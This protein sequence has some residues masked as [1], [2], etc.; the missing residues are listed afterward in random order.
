MIDN[1][2]NT[3]ETKAALG[4]AFPSLEITAI[5]ELGDFLSIKT[6][7]LHHVCKRLAAIQRDNGFRKIW[8][9]FPSD[10]AVINSANLIANGLKRIR[11]EPTKTMQRAKYAIYHELEAL[12]LEHRNLSDCLLCWHLAGQNADRIEARLRVLAP[13]AMLEEAHTSAI[14][15]VSAW[16]RFL[17]TLELAASEAIDRL[18]GPSY[19]ISLKEGNHAKRQLVGVA[20]PKLFTELTG[21]TL[22]T[23]KSFE[24]DGTNFINLCLKAIGQGPLSIETI[25]THLKPLRQSKRNKQSSATA[26]CGE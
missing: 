26:I 8:E 11:L 3:G 10:K 17:P 1:L 24:L 5:I 4:K 20:L 7:S 15:H 13:L 2:R 12:E 22:K 25:R 14:E 19:D 16:F 18:E 9:T 23:G 21:S 6:D